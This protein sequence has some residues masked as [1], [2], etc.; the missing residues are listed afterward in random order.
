MVNHPK[1]SCL[2]ENINGMKSIEEDFVLTLTSDIE[3][4]HLTETFSRSMQALYTYWGIIKVKSEQS[5]I[6]KGD[7]KE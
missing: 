5:R 2:K 7:F 1:V 6:H 4:L 3:I